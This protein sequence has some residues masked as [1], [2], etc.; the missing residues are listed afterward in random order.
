QLQ[1]A[2]A[3]GNAR[4]SATG[5]SDRN[6]ADR[7]AAPANG[8]SYSERDGAARRGVLD[9]ARSGAALR[10]CVGKRGADSDHG[11]R[12]LDVDDEEDPHSRRG[13]IEN[14]AFHALLLVAEGRGAIS[15]RVR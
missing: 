15:W 11:D 14:P 7:T 3:L 8:G 12:E 2:R 5:K 13:T 9:F 1:C 6:G 4:G 10:Y